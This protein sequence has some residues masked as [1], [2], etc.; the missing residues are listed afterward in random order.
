[1]APV[2]AV[3]AEFHGR[4]GGGDLVFSCGQCRAF[5]GVFALAADRAFGGVIHDSALRLFPSSAI[6]LPQAKPIARIVRAPDEVLARKKMRCHPE[7]R[8]VCVPKNLNLVFVLAS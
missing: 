8:D 2:A 1:M 5:G 4:G 6:G 7:G 3:G